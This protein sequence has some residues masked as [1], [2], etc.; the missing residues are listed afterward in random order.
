MTNEDLHVGQ[1]MALGGA[2][3]IGGSLLDDR[4][5]Q[6]LEAHGDLGKCDRERRQEQTPYIAEEIFGRFYVVAYGR[7]RENGAGQKDQQER[8]HIRR[9]GEKNVPYDGADLIAEFSRFSSTD[10]RERIRDEYDHDHGDNAHSDGDGKSLC[11]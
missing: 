6:E 7:K 4:R 1:T 8:S 3:V 10:D 5:S 9:N 11:H 2:D